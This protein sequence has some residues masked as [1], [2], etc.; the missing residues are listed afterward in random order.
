M[1]INDDGSEIEIIVEGD[2]KSEDIEIAAK[3]LC[4]DVFKFLTINPK[5]ND[6]ML[7][8]MQLITISFTN[9]SLTKR[10]I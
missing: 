4:P 10:F 3:I 7:G 5:W 9:Q 1:D 2:V 6:G 8:V